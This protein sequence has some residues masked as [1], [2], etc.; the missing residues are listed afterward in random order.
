MTF[1][2]KLFGKNNKKTCCNIKIEEVKAEDKKSCCQS[3]N[4]DKKST[5]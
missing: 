5:K 3:E 4:A 1:K 2:I